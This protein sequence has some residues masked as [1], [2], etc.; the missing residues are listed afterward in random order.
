MIAVPGDEANG[1][2]NYCIDSTEVTI[3]QY[4]EWLLDQPNAADQPEVCKAWNATHYPKTHN[5]CQ[6]FNFGDALKESP[7]RPIV[8][9]NWCDAASFCQWAGKRLCGRVAGGSNDFANDSDPLDSQWYRACSAGGGRKFPYGDEYDATACVG[10][11]HDG[12]P[13]Y[14]SSSDIPLPVGESGC[15][16]GFEDLFDMSGN[17]AEWEDACDSEEGQDD[18]CRVRAGSYMHGISELACS[19]SMVLSRKTVYIDFGFRCCAELQP[20]Q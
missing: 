10:E 2:T 15:K 7:E 6:G 1:V 5:N 8:C 14:Q 12:K 9:V 17:V 3:Q 20:V 19:S 13:G 16:G 18:P 11:D 4:N